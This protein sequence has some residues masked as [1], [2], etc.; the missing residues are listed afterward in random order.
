MKSFAMSLAV[1][2]LGAGAAFAAPIQ[3][4]APAAA[5]T[6]HNLPY[7]KAQPMG[8]VVSDAAANR[9]TQAL[10]LL[11]AKG[12]TSFSNFRPDGSDYSAKVMKNGR[13]MTVIVDPGNGHI[14]TQS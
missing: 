7:H 9:E 11:E 14:T 4:A 13:D 1:L 8:N 2:A 10:N 3:P 6:S 12:Y 5:N